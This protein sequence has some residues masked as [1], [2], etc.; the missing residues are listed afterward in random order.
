MQEWLGL[1]KAAFYF[2]V[3]MILACQWHW[4]CMMR[5]EAKGLREE[6]KKLEGGLPSRERRR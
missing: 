5:E 1:A 3:V 4:N 2:V 6:I